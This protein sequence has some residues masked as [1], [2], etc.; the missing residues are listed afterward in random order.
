MIYSMTGFGRC[1][2]EV[3]GKISFNVEIKGVNHRYLDINIR[4]PRMMNSLEDRIRK[5]ITKI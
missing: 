3:E 4:M 2:Y 5:L 1:G